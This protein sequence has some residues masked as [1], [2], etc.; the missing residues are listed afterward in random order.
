MSRTL[1]IISED[2]SVRA[3][4]RELL[5][6]DYHIVETDGGREAIRLLYEKSRVFS[7]V[8]LDLSDG[9]EGSHETLRKIKENAVLMTLPV[10]AVTADGS[11]EA[12]EATLAEGA[13]GVAAR[14]F[15]R[16]LLFQLKNSI[17][18]RETAAMV[19]A[20]LK[21]RLT[22]LYN[23]DAFIKEAQRI[24]RRSSAGYY[25]LSCFNIENFKIINE[26]YGV[27]KGDE[28]LRHIAR[29]LGDFADA[30]DGL[31]GRF[32][33]DK[34]MLL[35]PAELKSSDASL[36][37]H[38]A[39]KHPDCVPRP[40]HV[41]IG[42]YTVDDLALPL[43][44]MLDR[45]FLAEAS[46]KGQYGVFVA[47]YD[48]SM[49]Q[50][51]LREQ[52][53]VNSMAD[54]LKNGE[55]EPWYQPQYN[56]AT[57]ALIG[58]EAL[59]RW[60]RDGQIM[61]PADY[62]PIFERNGF[63]YQLDLYIWRQVCIQ[64][65]RWL[66]EGRTPLPVS[67]NISR[68]DV[69]QPDFLDSLTA[70]MDEYKLPIGLLRLEITE[71][72]FSQSSKLLL[73]TVN[74]LIDRGFTVEIDDFGSGY[75]SLNTLKD[76]P[77]SILK[78]DMR[79]FESTANSQ[80]GGNIVDSVVRMAKWLGMA[81]IAEGVE[82]R[83]Q[84]DYLK[85][86][87]CYYIQGYFYAKPMPLEEY[88][89]LLGKSRCEPRLS[90]TEALDTLDNNEFWNPKSIETLIFNSYVGGACIFE[91][92]GNKTELL[93]MNDQYARELNGLLLPG[94]QMLDASMV[95][96]MDE[97]SR[98][99]LL[100]AVHTADATNREAGCE[101]RLTRGEQTE[102]IRVTIRVIARTQGRCLCYAMI[103][104]MTAQREA[105]R[106]LAESARQLDVIMHNIGGGVSASLFDKGKAHYLFTNDR[107]YQLLGYTR[108]QFPVEC[109]NGLIDCLHPEDREQA[110]DRY[111]AMGRSYTTATNEFRVIRRDGKVIWLHADGTL[112]PFGQDGVMANLAVYTDISQMKQ[113][114][115]HEN[116]TARRFSA[117]MQSVNGGV[118]AV[119]ISDE[120]RSQIIFH[121]D[122]YYD[123][124]GYT[125]QEAEAMELDVM[126]LILPEDF[127]SVMEKVRQLKRDRAPTVI[128][129]RIRKKGGSLAYLRLNASLLTM[130]D[131]GE[132]IISVIV[133]ITEKRLLEEQFRSLSESVLTLMND[134][135]GGFVR[136]R[137]TP[138]GVFVPV[139]A[140]DGF[141]RMVET[142]HKTLMDIFGK[143]VLDGIHPEDRHIL[144]SA[145]LRML[146]SGVPES[147]RFRM[148]KGDGGYIWLEFNAKAVR[149]GGET[150][151]NVYYTDVSRQVSQE[152]AR[153]DLLDNLPNGAA[154]YSYDGEKLSVIHINKS[155]WRL[156]GRSP[157]DPRDIDLLSAVEPGDIPLIKKE[158][159]AAIRQR[160]NADVNLRIRYRGEGYRPF[161][162][163]ATVTDNGD[164]TYLL[165]VSFIPISNES[166]SVQEL[167]PIA[168][169]TM[170]SAAD[171]LSYVKDQNGRYLCC[172]DLA[173]AMLGLESA[174]DIVGK[175]DV[176]LFGAKAGAVV[177]ERSMR[178]LRSGE[179]EMGVI[180]KFRGD[181]GDR[182]ISTDI[183]PIRDTAGK[184]VGIYGSG[185]DITVQREKES[186]LELLT[187]SVPGGLAT[188]TI[189]RNGIKLQ[190]CNDGY[191][192]ALGYTREEYAAM[193]GADPLANVLEADRGRIVSLLGLFAKME[194]GED[195]DGRT[196][197]IEYRCFTKDG[198]LRWMMV[199][200]VLSRQSSR[201][202][203]LH[204]FRTDITE[205]QDERERLR[206]SEELNRLAIEQSGRIIGRFDVSGKTLSLPSTLPKRY[207]HE[208]ALRDVP[209]AQIARG[210]ISPE[211]AEV[212]RRFFSDISDGKPS[213]SVVYQQMSADGW[214]WLEA[215]STT[216]FSSEHRP[217]SAVISFT[218]VTEQREKEFV[219]SK[220]QQGL[221][222]RDKS[223]Y[224][225]YRCNLSKD[226]GYDLA[227]GELLD[228]IIDGD[229]DKS[230][231]RH[232]LDFAEKTVAAEDRAEY[233]RF[234][235]LNTLLADYRRGRRVGSLDFRRMDRSGALRWTRLDLELVEYPDSTDVAAYL[236]YEDIHEAKAAEL[237]T[238][239]K[240]ERDPLT[241][242]LNRGA[243]EERVDRA[244]S[245]QGDGVMGALFLLDMDGFKGINDRFGHAVGDKVLTDTGA[246]L[247]SVLRDC[248]MVGR[249]GGDEFVAF[250]T[251]MPN[252]D[253]ISRKAEALCAVTQQSFHLAYR[254][255][256]SLGVAVTPGD[257][258]S[259]AELYARADKALYYIKEH[260]KASYAFYSDAMHDTVLR[261]DE[262]EDGAPFGAR[263][264]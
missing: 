206:Q 200:T 227:Q 158:I 33:S 62:I 202:Y 19:T 23:R 64:L 184:V 181:G 130:E 84:A 120:G 161:H 178:V 242:L 98:T 104:N 92:H 123:L 211:T 47:D 259:F 193:A 253:S 76:V 176:D 66:D 80:R 246:L 237:E 102:Y 32:S 45:A 208:G 73:E 215:K 212:Y 54:A 77:A 113:A 137:L 22:K 59:V 257:G 148:R 262:T 38:K 26:Q 129:Y 198:G 179:P 44:T 108:E 171:N 133:D 185:R 236:M 118:S 143:N 28:V 101:V 56:H 217:A 199:K 25:L 248:D 182:V 233:L 115:K 240:A 258:E 11:D 238:R 174:R 81:V 169:S 50:Q 51:M 97:N 13:D 228:F 87:G 251:D 226:S 264:E 247:R 122:N 18:L 46:I 140:N 135:P 241:G 95:A 91:L 261:K 173:A 1:L 7:A 103:V 34:F 4:L 170:M 141:A 30:C 124:Y 15:R 40:I 116:E 150:Y 99:A 221:D 57:G 58:A 125:R 134:T 144:Q 204:I 79:F 71:S 222:G 88:E 201:Q 128:D 156:V 24:I 75:S 219:Y 213:G 160:R 94:T 260:G 10:I 190:Y 235:D 106:R 90:A 100:D 256:L 207:G 42:R 159:D 52:A 154:L 132:V 232:S 107:F 121:N 230:F 163:T 111:A 151:L 117:I 16:R 85:S 216:V 186:Q 146:E 224:S 209:E 196:D 93:R 48:G 8:L 96:L 126:S 70:L 167:F 78:L 223:T 263:E 183:Y 153:I 177:E 195:M 39:L 214:R 21:D 60:R 89:A 194:A 243:F 127:P 164:G 9:A 252:L 189:D 205:L 43:T 5:Q 2:P 65:R 35:F 157:A 162:A 41:R 67:V 234:V 136:L 109:P 110:L 145:A 53:I 49:L 172:S 6:T 55:F 69:V 239:V 175:R 72:A 131:Y 114:E 218:D 231:N 147:A 188:Y 142:D 255:S 14:P 229:S 36:H 180:E 105:E 12:A 249:L 138:E 82:D 112:C 20:T 37:V 27:E 119:K 244:I 168:M 83:A 187:R 152:Q 254:V 61:L 225:L 250:L 3:S 197:N 149:N 17:K 166:L 220:W 74:G 191:Y 29:E 155:Y 139:Y 68:F 86:I 210:R 31:A 165:H 63:I 203:M 245:A 192:T